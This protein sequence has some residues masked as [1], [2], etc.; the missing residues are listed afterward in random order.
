M[1][2]H[3]YASEA[4]IPQPHTVLDDEFMRRN[5]YIRTLEL[6]QGW[7]DLTED[8]AAKLLD[9]YETS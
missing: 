5:A 8:Q 4:D 9:P 6:P 1:Y 7:D 2:Y 3:C